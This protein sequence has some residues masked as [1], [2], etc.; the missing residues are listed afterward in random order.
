[1]KLLQVGHDAVE[2]SNIRK[3]HQWNVK[4]CLSSTDALNPLPLLLVG[5]EP[6]KSIHTFCTPGTGDLYRAEE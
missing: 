3:F 6:V 2:N 1:M 5:N 4:I